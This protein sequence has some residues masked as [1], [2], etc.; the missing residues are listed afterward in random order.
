VF[1]TDVRTERAS[2]LFYEAD[3]VLDLMLPDVLGTE[4]CRQLRAD[5]VLGGVAVLTFTA[6]AFGSATSGSTSRR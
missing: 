3:R 6:R 1:V 4:L 2:Y 5:P